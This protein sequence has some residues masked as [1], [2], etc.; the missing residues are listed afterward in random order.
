MFARE[1]MDSIPPSRRPC[2]PGEPVAEAP[3]G[4]AFPVRLEALE[5]FLRYENRLGQLQ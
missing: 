2:L 3:S 1:M 5:L 4:A